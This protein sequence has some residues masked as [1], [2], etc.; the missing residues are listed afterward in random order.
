MAIK[1]A[2]LVVEVGS[3]I[4]DA[5]RGLDT[6]NSKVEGVVKGLAVQGLEL[7]AAFTAPIAAIA[8]MGFEYLASKEQA[9]I[10][11]TSMLGDAQKAKAFLEDLQQFAA[12]TP[13]EFPDLIKSAQMMRAMG[14][15]A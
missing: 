3:D 9:N 12:K 14:V 6:I 1:A 2:E 8:K 7:S 4:K 10:A 5:E 13:F 11:F 15:A